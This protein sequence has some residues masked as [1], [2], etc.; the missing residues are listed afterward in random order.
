VR[1]DLVSA[2][3]LVP[4]VDPPPAP[5]L[6]IRRHHC[7]LAGEVA[8]I[9]AGKTPARERTASTPVAAMPDS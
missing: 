9:E 3:D 7:V 1:S 2:E 4:G 6:Q 8:Y 5:L